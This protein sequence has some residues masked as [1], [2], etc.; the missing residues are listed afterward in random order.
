MCL[1]FV[2]RQIHPDY[3][4]I[5][6]SNRDEFFQ[7]ETQAAHQWPKPNLQIKERFIAGKDLEAGGTWLAISQGGN[8]GAV[9]NVREPN[10][11]TLADLSRG[12]L[13]LI[14]LKQACRTLGKTQENFF[15]SLK[16]AIEPKASHSF[17]GYNLLAGNIA[18]ELYYLSNRFDA[19]PLSNKGIWGLSNASLDTNWPKVKAGKA[20]IQ[21]LCSKP[22]FDAEDWFNLMHDKTTFPDQELPSTGVPLDLERALSATFIHSP[23]YGTRTTTLITLDHAKKIRFYERNFN[24]EGLV[25]SEPYFEWTLTPHS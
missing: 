11:Q 22:S 23:N 19:Q 16:Q 20:K 15:T 18:G 8:L 5:L 10:T 12:K 2:A 4:F 3:P 7:R 13:P 17:G 25:I 9:T 14:S 6:I 1:I 24:H 21:Q